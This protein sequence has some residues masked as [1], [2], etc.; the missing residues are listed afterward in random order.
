[1]AVPT[2]RRHVR[3]CYRQEPKD[4]TA[5]H[6]FFHCF[7]HPVR[8]NSLNATGSVHRTPHPTRTH[9]FFSCTSHIAHAHSAWIKCVR[10]KKSAS[11]SHPFPSRSLMSM[12]N[13]PFVRLSQPVQADGFKA[14]AHPLA[15]PGR[16]T[17]PV[18]HTGVEPKLAD[19]FSC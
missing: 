6:M 1:M 4:L 5:F 17:D 10:C 3:S 7:S 12:L 8:R 11:F 15:G 14:Q 18:P 19:F 16:M 9:A 13:V 2:S